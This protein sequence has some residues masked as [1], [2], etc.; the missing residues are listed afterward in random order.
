MNNRIGSDQI[1]KFAAGAIILIFSLACLYPLLLTFMVSISDEYLVQINGFKLIPEKFSLDTYIF[2]YKTNA[3]RILNAYGV[4]TLVTAGGTVLALIFTS[5]LAFT[6]SL[7]TVKYR[8]A[9]SFFCYFTVIFPAGMIPW[10]IVCVNVL[11]L[12]NTWFALILP[13]AVNVWNLFLLRNYFQ[14]I[15]DSIL[16]SARIDGA[17]DFTVFSRLVMPM[18]R[19]ALLTV[20]LFYA[21]QFWN[22]WWL[23][24]MLIS[25]REMYPMQFFLFNILSSVNALSS[26]MLQDGSRIRVPTETVKMAV[27]IVTVLPI[28]FLFPLIQKHFIKGIMV[29][30]VKG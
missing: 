15:P 20:G 14:S 26:G 18:S 6:I 9:I 22:D 23:S 5:M 10:Y 3:D 2:L 21:I 12:K 1:L 30:A 7:K 24:I 17:N 29:G 8:G 19:T 16:E 13:Y 11:Q 27:T 4:T 28:L 25:K